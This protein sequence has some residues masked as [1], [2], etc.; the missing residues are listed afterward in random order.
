MAHSSDN[1]IPTRVSLLGRVKNLEDQQS[2]KDFFNTYRG[3]IHGVALKAGLREVEAQEVVQETF[4][5]VSKKMKEFQYNPKVGSFKSWLLHT[6]QWRI[7]DQFRKR[8]RELP[9]LSGKKFEDDRT[10]TVERIPDPAGIK[11]EALWEEEWEKTIFETA[12]KKVRGQV[13]ARQYQLFDLYVVKGWPVVKVARA[14]GVNVSHVYL[15]KH[16]VS[17]LLK[18][19]M[20]D[21]RRDTA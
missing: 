8:A 14:L 13:K 6:T 15:A 17:L 20:K 7:A 19:E 18:K 12:L 2:W 4:I 9:Q 16:R 10:A 11:L 1:L 3:L 5:A 21:L